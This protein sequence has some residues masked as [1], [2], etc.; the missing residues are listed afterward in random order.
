MIV[1]RRT[2]FQSLAAT[3]LA[4]QARSQA[5][6]TPGTGRERISKRWWESVATMCRV[7][8]RPER[9]HKAMNLRDETALAS[10]LDQMRAQGVYSLEV[11]A[12]A[13]GGYSFSGLDTIDRYRLQPE[14]GTMDDFRRLV[15]MSHARGLPIISFD[16]LG[17]SSV[18]AVDFLK[19]CDDIKA[20]R[21]T[22]ESKFYLWS[23]REDAPPPGRDRGNTY[24]MVR[25]THLKGYDS[26]KAE[27]WTWSDRAGKYYWSKWGGVDLQRKRARL[28]QYNWGTTEFQ[29]EAER[30]IRFWM[31]T[32]IDGM[33]IDAVNW[34]VDYTWQLGQQRITKVIESYGNA[35]SQPEGAGGFHEDPAPWVT[36]GGW[37]SVQD[38]GLGIWWEKGSDVIEQALESGDPRPIERALRDY[39]DRVVAA[40]AVL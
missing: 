6:R 7:H 29:D 14:A 20:G 35:Y 21:Q 2:A 26:S 36:E 34:Y 22:R 33:V 19:A 18:E 17:Y 13:H 5:R 1:S 40:G 8:I 38:Y 25:P 3:A 23:D 37:N 11:F 24:F 10:E 15:R 9:R 39:R 16:N 28:P 30:I 27:L 12:P 4:P 31:D 32:G